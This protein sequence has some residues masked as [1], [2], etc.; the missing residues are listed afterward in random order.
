M[1]L[2]YV[3]SSCLLL[4]FILVVVIRWNLGMPRLRWDGDVVQSREY[5]TRCIQ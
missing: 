5:T 3:Y 4:Y 2:G 1:D